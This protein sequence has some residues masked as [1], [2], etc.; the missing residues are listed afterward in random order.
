MAIPSTPRKRTCSIPATAWVTA[1]ACCAARIAGQAAAC[2]HPH[3]L[4]QPPRVEKAASAAWTPQVR[5]ERGAALPQPAETRL[6]ASCV[7][8]APALAPRRPSP[9]ASCG[10]RSSIATSTACARMLVGGQGRC[11]AL[12][13]PA[14]VTLNLRVWTA[15]QTEPLANRSNRAGWRAS[16]GTGLWRKSTIGVFITLLHQRAQN[17]YLTALY[18][19]SSK[20]C[21]ISLAVTHAWS[22]MLLSAMLSLSPSVTTWARK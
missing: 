7:A 15:I 14:E 21:P 17:M 3:A 12:R 18:V 16:G 2:S 5:P 19:A 13:A 22:D 1:P 8:A 10:R 6:R 4:V 20:Y 9:C 11:T